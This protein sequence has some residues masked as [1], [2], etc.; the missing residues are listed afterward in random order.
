MV[1]IAFS[2]V[3]ITISLWFAVL[4]LGFNHLYAADPQKGEALFKQ[5]CTSCH[6]VDAQLVGPALKGVEE[7][8]A[9][10]KDWLYKWIKNNQALIKANDP[11][12]IAIYNQ[13]GKQQ[14]NVFTFL[15]DADIDDILKYVADYKPTVDKPSVATSEGDANI[16]DDPKIYYTLLGL[17]ALLLGIGL[18]LIFGTAALVAAVRAKD[19]QRALSTSDVYKQFGDF[20]RNRFVAGCLITVVLVGGTAKLIEAARG[21]SLH[22]NYMPEQPIKYSH[23]L[24]AGTNKIQC[25]YCHSGASKSKNAWVPSTNV[26]MNCHKAVEKGPTYGKGEIGKIYVS[27]GWNPVDKKYF[28]PGTSQDTITAKFKQWLDDEKKS[29]ELFEALDVKNKSGKAIEWVRIHNLPDHAYFNHAQHVTVGGQRCQ[30]CH[31]EIQNMEV[32]YQHAPL[33]MGWCVQCHRDTKVK[34][35]GQ[36]TEFTVED[37]GG[38]DCAKCHY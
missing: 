26:C 33:S 16:L 23:K 31:G 8:Y 12:A 1:K 19:E 11:K 2:N 3:R 21:V 30:T 24:H 22:Q 37:Q 35:L 5:H 32:V 9:N 28:A 15:T 20:L 29:T 7:K 17:A 4:L 38:L 34:S 14:M 27:A 18:I 13:F 25:Q 10:D 6:K 36:D